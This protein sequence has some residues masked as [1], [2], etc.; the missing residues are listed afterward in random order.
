M[1]RQILGNL[2]RLLLIHL[3]RS[4]VG[5]DVQARA[6]YVA[7]EPANRHADPPADLVLPEGVQCQVDADTPSQCIRLGEVLPKA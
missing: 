2:H 6:V 5:G 7:C 4:N 1:N 3:K